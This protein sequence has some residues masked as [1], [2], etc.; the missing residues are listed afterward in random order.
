[1]AEP[2]ISMAFFFKTPHASFDLHT[3]FYFWN[4]RRLKL[5]RQK[6]CVR[7]IEQVETFTHLATATTL[8]NKIFHSEYYEI[9]V[10]FTALYLVFYPVIFYDFF[11]CKSLYFHTL[12]LINL[13]LFNFHRI[14]FL[15]WSFVIDWKMKQNF[16]IKNEI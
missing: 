1:M 7:L 2:F 6:A 3:F 10:N 12:T 9:T 11:F 8:F 16:R 13:I 5:N 15:F 14:F 4:F